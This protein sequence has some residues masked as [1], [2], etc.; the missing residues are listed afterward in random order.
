MAYIDS[1]NNRT[2]RGMTLTELL[3][4]LLLMAILSA[5][6]I[7]I[8]YV[9]E[10]HDEIE[11]AARE[12][13]SMMDLARTKAVS[14]TTVYSLVLVTRTDDHSA[15]IWIDETTPTKKTD[16]TVPPISQSKVEHPVYFEDFI[17]ME[18]I[19]ASGGITSGTEMVFYRFFP[20]GSSDSGK[21]EVWIDDDHV[22]EIKSKATVNLQGP[23]ATSN[24]VV[25]R[26][27]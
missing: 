16:T 15:A 17:E 14:D 25:D 8:Y 1:Q 13:T 21:V 5:I 26:N 4:V 12:L 20:D 18:Y 22:D 3:I 23:T 24:I 11:G 2:R 6:G 19:A 9:S 10:R 7:S 27:P